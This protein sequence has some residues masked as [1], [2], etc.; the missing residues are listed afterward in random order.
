MA[1]VRLTQ[2]LRAKISREAVHAF[3]V[4]NPE[5]KPSTEFEQRLRDAIPRVPTQIALKNMYDIAMENNVYETKAFGCNNTSNKLNFTTLDKISIE[6]LDTPQ[7]S[8]F[9]RGEVLIELSAPVNIIRAGDGYWGVPYQINTNA[10]AIE[11]QTYITEQSNELL[12]KRVQRDT[13]DREYKDT[14]DDLLKRCNTVKQL[15]EI[16]PAAENLIPQDLIVKLHEKV[17]RKQRAQQV[18]EEIHFNA[19]EINKV[20]LTAKLMGA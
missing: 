3:H 6:G 8:P 14:I 9:R 1:S 4:A 20:V 2:E 11:D 13:K 15:L 18:K 12:K 5:P 10:F 17:T 19:D 16:W 7:D